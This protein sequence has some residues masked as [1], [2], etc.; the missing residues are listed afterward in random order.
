MSNAT[1]TDV[2]VVGGG[3][4]GASTAIRLARAGHSVTLVERRTGRSPFTR[5]DL[6]DP[7][8]VR[9]LAHLDIATDGLATHELFGT[10]LWSSDRSVPIRWPDG[11][12][13]LSIRRSDLNRALL[14]TCS[15]AGVD[16][17]IGQEAVAPIVERGFVRGATVA[18]TATDASLSV[19]PSRE[20]GCRF[21]VVAD[22]ANSR[23]GRGLGT[24]RDRNWPYAISASVYFESRRSADR[25]VDIV[26]GPRDR[27][28]NPVTGHGWVTPV[29]DGTVN[30]GVTM[31]SSYRDVLGVN[32]LK[33]LDT[34]I[35]DVAARWHID[36][37]ARLT[38]PVRRRTPVG[39]SVRPIMGP[40]FLVAGDAAGMANPF[41]GHGIG[42]ALMTG[43]IAADVLDEALSVGNSTTLQRYP[44]LLD[45][46]IGTYH[47]VGRLSARFLGRPR[48]LKFALRS[49]IRSEEAM[50]AAMRIAT[51]ELRSDDAGGAERAYRLA[52]VVS[53]FAPSW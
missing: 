21:L 38:D 39:G 12:S 5:G 2:L 36:P 28:D 7:A 9:E 6:L 24:N 45:D 48:L 49:G 53:R 37:S 34:V 20:I 1:S 13:G 47:K 18:D 3:P 33:L 29:A 32:T 52:Q 10:R 11:A 19:Q 8:T 46:E 42:A 26:L 30:V 4:A 23:F 16:V 35:D 41:N 25:W 22:G 43:R 15:D 51:N 31:V 44:A 40:T 17:V 50:G 14:D 27:N